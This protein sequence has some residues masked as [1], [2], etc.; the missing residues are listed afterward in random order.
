MEGQSYKVLVKTPQTE[1][2][3]E[4]VCSTFGITGFTKEANKN[5]QAVYELNISADQLH[6][7]KTGFTTNANIEFL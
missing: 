3:F 4:Q 2:E 1:S 5:G 6:L 7:L